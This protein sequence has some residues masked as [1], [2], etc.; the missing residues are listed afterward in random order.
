[1]AGPASSFESSIFATFSYRI[2][3]YSTI[4]IR[5][6]GAPTLFPP[7]TK[8]FR[9]STR[10]TRVV[11]TFYLLN[12]SADIMTAIHSSFIFSPSRSPMP[13]LHLLNFERERANLPHRS[14][15]SSTS[16]PSI[17]ARFLHYQVSTTLHQRG[18]KRRKK[19]K[20][21]SRI[22]S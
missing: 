12:N 13:P 9:H 14:L 1:M 17:S 22:W 10:H 2:D 20:E 4:P 11:P 7:P 18:G 21:Y 16:I 8:V 6:P 19:K 15:H 5:N 3:F